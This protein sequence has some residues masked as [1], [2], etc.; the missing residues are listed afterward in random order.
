MAT[1]QRS[2]IVERVNHMYQRFFAD[3]DIDPTTGL[4]PCGCKKFATFPYIGSRYGLSGVR[5]LLVVGLDIGG[6]ETPGRIQTLEKRCAEIEC[7]EV[8]KHNPHIAGTYM[9]ALYLPRCELPEWLE[10][11]RRADKSATC[12]QLLKRKDELPAENPL[13]YIALTNYHKFVTVNREGRRGGQDRKFI[14]Q[15]LEGKLLEDEVSALDCDLVVFQGSQ[16]FSPY[17]GTINQISETN[18]QIMHAGIHPS[19]SE[20]RRLDSIMKSLYER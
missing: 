11:W 1:F 14:N 4:L 20:A 8:S 12:Q 18:V 13:A 15:M 2:N 3:M 16:F 7:K 5:R 10:Y 19:A 9:M 17:S 6:D